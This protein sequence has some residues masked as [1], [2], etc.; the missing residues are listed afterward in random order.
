MVGVCLWGG[1]GGSWGLVKWIGVRFY[2][3]KGGGRRGGLVSTQLC[4]DVSVSKS[5]GH[6]SFRDCVFFKEEIMG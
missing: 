4:M 6:G 3:G 1:G 5:E 2:L